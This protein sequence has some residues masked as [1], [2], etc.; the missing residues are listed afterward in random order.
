MQEVNFQATTRHEFDD[1][2][3][4]PFGRKVARDHTALPLLWPLILVGWMAL[5]FI[6]FFLLL[7]P[8]PLSEVPFLTRVLVSTFV[9]LLALKGFEWRSKVFVSA[10]AK[11]LFSNAKGIPTLMAAFSDEAFR[12]VS[13]VFGTT[14]LQTAAPL[15]FSARWIFGAHFGVARPGRVTLAEVV[16]ASTANPGPFASVMI[17]TKDLQ[18]KGARADSVPP[19]LALMDGGLCDNYADQWP[20]GME[21]RRC[22]IDSLKQDAVLATTNDRPSP[23]LPSRLATPELATANKMA[24]KRKLATLIAHDREWFDLKRE[25]P[26]RQ[27]VLVNATQQPDPTWQPSALPIIGELTTLYRVVLIMLQAALEPRKQPLVA[28]LPPGV[29]GT[30]KHSP[31]VSFVDQSIPGTPVDIAHSPFDVI[32]RFHRKDT[33]SFT[34]IFTKERSERAE[35]VRR[36]LK[37]VER[38]SN[39][40]ESGTSPPYPLPTSSSWQRRCV[41]G[42]DRGP[43]SQSKWARPWSPSGRI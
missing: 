39:Q 36:L 10:Y 27:L 22:G 12:P 9:L 28:G 33:D 19:N 20:R 4:G 13:H 32:A 43:R 1:R 15:Y 18:F 37:E 7:A 17:A 40:S 38:V 26:P 35:D 34:P 8:P 23:R 16:T 41:G 5:L 24:I 42:G 30:S 25:T 11:N 21:A 29:L 3:F 6:S 2:V 14:S 31:D